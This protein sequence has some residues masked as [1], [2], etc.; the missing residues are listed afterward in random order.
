MPRFATDFFFEAD[1][2]LAAVDFRALFREADFFPFLALFFVA[3]FF[4]TLLLLFSAP[5]PG[6]Y[7]SQATASFSS[8]RRKSDLARIPGAFAGQ[9]VMRKPEEERVV[10]SSGPGGLRV[11]IRPLVRTRRA[12]RRLALAAILLFA[13][14]LFGGSRIVSAWEAGLRRG[15]FGDLPLPWLAALTAAVGLFTPLAVLGLAA[16]AFAEE[17]VQVGPDSV[18]ISTTSFERTRVRTI[19]LDELECW[20]QT[21]LPLSP[22]WT[23]AVER[24]AARWRGRLEPLAGAAGPKEKKWIARLL[25]EATGKPLIDDFGRRRDGNETRGRGD[26]GTRGS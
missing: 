10:V 8:G 2:R 3:F 24:L 23:W 20:R 14:V 21:L 15:D 13:S 1:R 12:R 7:N 22:W 18:T 11:E 16:L 6:S 9:Y 5:E 25:A 4:A 19:P 17:T 26:A